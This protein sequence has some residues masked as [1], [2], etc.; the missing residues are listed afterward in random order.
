MH[1]IIF[2]LN[3]WAPQIYKSPGACGC[4]LSEWQILKRSGGISCTAAV[5]WV[6][7]F[8]LLYGKVLVSTIYSFSQLSCIATP[9]PQRRLLE[10]SW[11]P[12]AS[13]L[14]GWLGHKVLE[15]IE[16]VLWSWNSGRHCIL[17]LGW[18]NGQFWN[19]RRG[20]SRDIVQIIFPLVRF[21]RLSKRASTRWRVPILVPC[22][23][24]REFQEIRI[25][26]WHMR[27]SQTR[28]RLWRLRIRKL[29]Q[30]LQFVE[31][32]CSHVGARASSGHRGPQIRKRWVSWPVDWWHGLRPRWMWPHV[33]VR[34]ANANIG[35]VTCAAHIRILFRLNIVA[36]LC[37]S[38]RVNNNLCE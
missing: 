1:K 11:T 35:P 10:V 38:L 3:H 7:D 30:L 14:F 18:A 12:H 25:R 36:L 5:G 19:W 15:A 6:I 27:R 21:P 26:I 23:R 37:S 13:E 34:L 9:I 17:K 22:C 4:V 32:E 2:I 24:V 28:R 8:M 29:V 31:Y 20:I 33:V 16:T